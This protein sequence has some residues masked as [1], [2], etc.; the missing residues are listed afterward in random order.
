MKP[1]LSNVVVFI[2]DRPL[3]AVGHVSFASKQKMLCIYYFFLKRKRNF[4]DNLI[5]RISEQLLREL[6]VPREVEIT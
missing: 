2:F 6:F 5:E 4:Q 3:A 1:N